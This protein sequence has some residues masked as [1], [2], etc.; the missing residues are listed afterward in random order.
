VASYFES[1]RGILLQAD[2]SVQH[3]V[4]PAGPQHDEDD[5]PVAEHAPE[6]HDDGPAEAPSE[7]DGDDDRTRE[8][9]HAHSDN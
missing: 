6:Q 1:L 9:E 3:P 5:E 7:G 8:P 2:A 4:F